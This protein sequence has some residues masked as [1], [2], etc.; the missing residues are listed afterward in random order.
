DSRAY[1]LHDGT[2]RRITDDHSLVEEMVREG[3]LTAEQAESH[4][5]RSIVTRALGVDREVEVDLYTIEVAAGDRVLLCSDG[6]TTMVRDR[7]VER[8]ARAET[9]P[10]RAAEVLVEAA[11]RAG[12]EDNTSVVIVDVVEVDAAATP[13]P[14]LLATPAAAPAFRAM[15]P[16]PDVPAPPPPAPP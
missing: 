14:D 13:D 16:A 11:N 15:A 8:L 4:P 2:L 9:D 6:L 10:Q 12:G 3:R 7:D 5:R 1:L